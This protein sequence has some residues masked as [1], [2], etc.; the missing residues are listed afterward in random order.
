MGLVLVTDEYLGFDAEK[1]CQIT[2]SRSCFVAIDV[3]ATGQKYWHNKDFF[4]QK[5]HYQG[6]SK[7]CD[8]MMAW[9]VLK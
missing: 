2:F 7:Q 9:K 4:P 3:S 1:T 5:K 6:I 8:Q